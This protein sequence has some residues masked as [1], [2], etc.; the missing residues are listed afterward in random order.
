[1]YCYS[2]DTHIKVNIYYY[3]TDKHIKVNMYWYSTETH[4]KV[5]IYYYSTYTHIKVNIYYYGTETHFKVN[6][7]CYS[8]EKNI[9]VNIFWYSTEPHI[10]EKDLFLYCFIFLTSIFSTFPSGPKMLIKIRKPIDP[11]NIHYPY[12]FPGFHENSFFGV[13]SFGVLS[14]SVHYSF[15]PE[16]TFLEGNQFHEPW[17]TLHCF[18]GLSVWWLGDS[19]LWQVG[20][21]VQLLNDGQMSK[22][23]YTSS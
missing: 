23:W 6:M 8:T 13:H 21:S 7:Y 17:G 12:T 1:M 22:W 15:I 4:I 2:T 10:K 18:W 14:F 5:N 19:R 11:T 9:K 3:S 16:C 20:Q